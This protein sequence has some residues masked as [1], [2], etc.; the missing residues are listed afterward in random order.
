M[1]A[2]IDEAAL[3]ARVREV[4]CNWPV[5]GLAVGVVKSGSLA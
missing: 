4:L 3:R 1:S 5:V 2:S